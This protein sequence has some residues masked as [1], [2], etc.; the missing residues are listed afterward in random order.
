MYF[1][2]GKN[3]IPV[4]S[5]HLVESRKNMHQLVENNTLKFFFPFDLWNKV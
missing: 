3:V 5:L 1:F 2:T 4:R